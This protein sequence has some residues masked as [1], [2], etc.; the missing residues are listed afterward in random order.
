[1]CGQGV[2]HSR[3][4]IVE[5]ETKQSS[6]IV[7]VFD[8]W[9]C[10]RFGWFAGGGVVCTLM[11]SSYLMGDINSMCVRFAG[12][13]WVGRFARIVLGYWGIGHYWRYW[14]MRQREQ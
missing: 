10:V 6:I 12:F 11:P 14:H 1:M 4:G 2:G 8:R 9:V 3:A 7:Q 5:R 13:G